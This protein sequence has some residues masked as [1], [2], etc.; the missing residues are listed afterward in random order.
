MGVGFLKIIKYLCADVVMAYTSIVLANIF[1]SFIV[2]G[3]TLL[4]GKSFYK[5]VLAKGINISQKN[6]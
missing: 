1:I 4:V 3:I 2:C 6:E 5:K